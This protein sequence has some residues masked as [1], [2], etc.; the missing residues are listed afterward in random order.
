MK[1]IYL[2]EK[3]ITFNKFYCLRIFFSKI[4]Y[5]A[6]LKS[7]IKLFSDDYYF[8]FGFCLFGDIFNFVTYWN[9]KM[10]HAGFNFEITIFGL[11]FYFHIH[12]TRHWDFKE[13][14]WKNTYIQE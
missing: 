6:P 10:D 11:S 5:I 4:E 8:K 12:D 2:K 7:S 1:N 13:N 9:R 3:K 14:N